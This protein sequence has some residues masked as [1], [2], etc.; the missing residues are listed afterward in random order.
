M[1]ER[2][3]R[4]HYLKTY[5]EF[6]QATKRGDKNFELRIDDRDYSVGDILVL[7]EYDP[8]I[9][10]T[11]SE[12]IWLRVTYTLAKQPYVPRGYICMSTVKWHAHDGGGF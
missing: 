8:A 4:I 3:P 9:G 10:F 12:D 7:M 6:F 11:K 5:I 1:V 2:A